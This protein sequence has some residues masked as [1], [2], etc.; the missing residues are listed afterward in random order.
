M[1]PL[2]GDARYFRHYADAADALMMPLIFA[3]IRFHAAFA[4]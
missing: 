1:L 3:A 4:F 2:A